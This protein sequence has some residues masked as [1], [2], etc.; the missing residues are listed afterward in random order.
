MEENEVLMAVTTS[1]KRATVTPTPLFVGRGIILAVSLL[2]RDLNADR[3]TLSIQTNL[4]CSIIREGKC[5]YIQ[6]NQRLATVI[7]VK[8]RGDLLRITFIHRVRTSRRLA[9]KSAGIPTFELEAGCAFPSP[10]SVAAAD[11]L[12]QNLL[13]NH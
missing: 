1:T 13:R 2:I 6:S 8:Y 7:K 4:V 3:V 5:R 11:N 12:S 9:K 10:R